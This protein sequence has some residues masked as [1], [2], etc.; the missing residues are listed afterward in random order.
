MNLSPSTTNDA[1]WKVLTPSTKFFAASDDTLVTF[2][3]TVFAGRREGTVTYHNA[4]MV[5]G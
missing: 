3:R 5:V 4:F 1:V 2:P